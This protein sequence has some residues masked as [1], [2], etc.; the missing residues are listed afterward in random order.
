MTARLL[1][2]GCCT[3]YDQKTVNSVKMNN[4]K[5][6]TITPNPPRHLDNDIQKSY[7]NI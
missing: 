4:N 2:L 3:K 5:V 7:R 1:N 6:K